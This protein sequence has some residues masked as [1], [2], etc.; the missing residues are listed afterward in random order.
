VALWDAEE[1]M[2]A[3]E[4][5]V[6]QLRSD[7]AEVASETITGVDRYEVTFGEIRGAQV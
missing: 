4:E 3:S 6:N 7:A 5:A 1:A 2:R